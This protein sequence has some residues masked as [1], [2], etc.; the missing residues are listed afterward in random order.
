MNLP[1]WVLPFKEPHTAIKCITGIYYKYAVTYRY[2]P[3]RKRTIPKSGVLL[4]KITEQDGFVLS[5]KHTVQV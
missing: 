3:T 5:P 4:G 1:S 2:E